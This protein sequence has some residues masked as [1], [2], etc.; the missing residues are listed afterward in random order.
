METRAL[1]ACAGLY[2]SVE[3]GSGTSSGLGLLAKRCSPAH[4]NQRCDQYNYVAVYKICDGQ[5]KQIVWAT[6]S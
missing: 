2:T 6:K 5:V 3:F 4:P 1:S